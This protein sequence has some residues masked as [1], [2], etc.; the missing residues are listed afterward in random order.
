MG[1]AEV[2]TRTDLGAMRAELRAEI[3]ASNSAF[4]RSFLLRFVATNAITVG[5]VV[6]IARG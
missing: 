4:A 5:L 3:K 2:A 1:W 6:A